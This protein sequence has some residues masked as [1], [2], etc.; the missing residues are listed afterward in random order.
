MTRKNM[1]LIDFKYDKCSF[2][3]VRFLP[4]RE[5]FFNLYKNIEK[6]KYKHLVLYENSRE[7]DNNYTPHIIVCKKKLT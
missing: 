3:H 6:G 4:S 2:S 5:D 7:K 1:H